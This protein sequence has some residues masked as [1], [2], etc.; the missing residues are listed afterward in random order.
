MKKSA[1]PATGSAPDSKHQSAV[2]PQEYGVNAGAEADDDGGSEIKTQVKQAFG[3]LYD[4][5]QAGVMSAVN[6]AMEQPN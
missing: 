2:I 5:L 6:N 4:K 1:L 3:F